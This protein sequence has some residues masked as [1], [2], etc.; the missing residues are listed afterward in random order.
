M[1]PPVG[2][3]TLWL[4][5]ALAA[6]ALAGAQP[7]TAHGPSVKLS[8]EGMRPTEIVIAAG[9]TIHFQNVSSTARTFTL[10]ADDGS[11]ESPSM[12]RGEGWHHTFETAGRFTYFVR[13][14]P[15][16]KGVVT[17]APAE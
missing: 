17:V 9:Q 3:S 11:F 1:P 13:E 5:L 16:R 8:Y 6:L 12:P 2:K 4:P 15:D 7:A 10:V 14:N